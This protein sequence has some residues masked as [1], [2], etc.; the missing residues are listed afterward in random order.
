[1]KKF[2]IMRHGLAESGGRDYERPLSRRGREQAA[3]QAHSLKENMGTIDLAITSGATR[4]VQTL[5]AL[6]SAGLQVAQVC[7]VPSLYTGSWS[8]VVEEIREKTGEAQSV[9]VIGHEP[10]V[11]LISRLLAAEDSPAYTQLG[12]GFSTAQYVWGTLDSWDDLTER[13]W[14]VRG[15]VRPA[16]A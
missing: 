10:T 3:L 6:R 12:Y 16:T 2:A 11:S 14:F 7:E 15:L 5:V 1:M 13:A 4:T 9:L 8:D